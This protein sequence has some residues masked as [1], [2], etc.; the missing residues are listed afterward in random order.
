MRER[1]LT[2]GWQFSIESRPGGGTHVRVE[3]KQ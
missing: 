3:A 1:A 2:H